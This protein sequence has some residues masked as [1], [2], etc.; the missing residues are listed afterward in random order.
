MFTLNQLKYAS[1]LARRTVLST[2]TP[3]RIHTEITKDTA[4]LFRQLQI[5]VTVAAA[6][7]TDW[8]GVR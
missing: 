1:D 3:T 7:I 8:D 6:K 5:Q 4:V 2:L